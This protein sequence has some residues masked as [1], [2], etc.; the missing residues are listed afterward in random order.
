MNVGNGP[1]D[2][3]HFEDRFL[4]HLVDIA[5]DRPMGHLDGVLAENVAARLASDAEVVEGLAENDGESVAPPRGV[6]SGTVKELENEGLLTVPVSDKMSQY[7][8]PTKEG[9]RRVAQ[10]REEWNRQRNMQDRKVQ[11]LILQELERQWRA[12]PEMYKFRSSLDVEAFC[13]ANDIEYTVYLANAHRL[14][15]QGKVG[16]PSI[17][18]AGPDS[19]FMHITEPGRRSLEVVESTSRPQRNEQEAWV[20]VARLRRRL[21]IAERDLSSLVA[22]EELRQRCEDLLVADAHYDRVIREACVILEDR[23]RKAI[24]VGKSSYGVSLMEKAFGKNGLLKLSDEEP[25][26]IGAMQ[27]YRGVMAFFRNT[28]GHNLIDSYDQ[29]DALRFVVLVDLLLKTMS[30]ASI[31]PAKKSDA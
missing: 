25:E 2:L 17:A 16:T 24:G 10:W 30:E 23:V 20:Q 5:G 6:V 18:G 21:Q 28:A 19:G 4:Y 11:R 13:E 8:R 26:Q 29:D 15:D 7:L 31:N 12:D 14:V 3:S 1:E 27:I 9:R 22:D